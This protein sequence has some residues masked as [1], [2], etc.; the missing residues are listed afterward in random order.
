[1][2][3]LA[4][5]AKPADIAE[6]RKATAHFA[7]RKKAVEQGGRE[8]PGSPRDPR[9]FA[10]GWQLV[11]PNFESP[12]ARTDATLSRIGAG[13]G[14]VLVLFGGR[15]A[16]SLAPPVL[17]LF[18]PREGTW[19]SPAQLN[20]ELSGEPPSARAGHTAGNFGRH[21]VLVYGGKTASGLS[22][23]VS[24]LVHHRPEIGTFS[25]LSWC[26]I[27]TDGDATPGARAY[28]AVAE[29]AESLMLFGGEVRM[30]M[31]EVDELGKKAKREAL[32]LL[33]PLHTRTEAS[34][35]TSTSTPTLR[36]FSSLL[37]SSTIPPTSGRL[38]PSASRAL[39]KAVVARCSSFP[40]IAACSSIHEFLYRSVSA[41]M[42]FCVSDFFLRFVERAPSTELVNSG[43]AVVAS[44]IL[45]CT[46]CT[47]SQ[48]RSLSA[49]KP[50]SSTAIQALRMRGQ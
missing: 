11:S 23:E 33:P 26:A 20:M 50:S 36:L 41:A 30:R 15:D 37:G 6:L 24:A 14:A 28:H 27:E 4:K 17:H 46:I 22:D 40:S 21:L 25:K 13:E 47:P 45:A 43:I 18:D 7:K 34:L 8:R 31:E 38:S 2:I 44:S 39:A 16:A 35:V 48:S 19:S 12:T 32:P 29:M 9:Q 5:K 42:L 1:M 10:I 49:C 3:P